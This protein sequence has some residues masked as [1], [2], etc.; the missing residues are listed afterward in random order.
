MGGGGGLNHNLG[1]KGLKLEVRMNKVG[2]KDWF[3]FDEKVNF[4][5][6]LPNSYVLMTAFEFVSSGVKHSSLLALIQFQD[7][8]MTFMRLRLNL[9]IAD[10]AYMFAISTSTTSVVILK[11]I[12]IAYNRLEV[13]LEW[14]SRDDILATTPMSFRQHFKTKDAVIVDCFEVFCHKPKNYRA[15]AE[16]FS[17]YKHHTTVKFLIGVTP[18][19]VISFV[20]KAWGGRTPDKHL[21]ENCGVLKYLLPGDTCIYE[22]KKQL[23]AFDVERSGKLAS[24]PFHVERVI[25]D[26]CAAQKIYD[27]ARHTTLGLP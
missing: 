1:L 11:W 14:P 10:L 8:T 4:N 3:N 2:T 6:G 20:S 5:T 22:R 18:Q 9:A 25:D 27:F 12:D 17:S 21:T 13:M 19:G 24:V 7:F 23:S 15:K 26:R 16:T